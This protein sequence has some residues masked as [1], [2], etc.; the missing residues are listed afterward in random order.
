MPVTKLDNY[1][2]GLSVESPNDL[3]KELKDIL[4]KTFE[5]MSTQYIENPTDKEE[6]KMKYD[7]ILSQAHEFANKINSLLQLLHIVDESQTNKFKYEDCM[8]H[9][10]GPNKL[11]NLFLELNI[12]SFDSELKAITDCANLKT[13]EQISAYKEVSNRKMALD[14]SEKVDSFNSFI[15]DYLLSLAKVI[16]II[17]RTNI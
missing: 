10:M 11:A 16:V 1:F 8:I 12:D 9:H 13:E 4:P 14:F 17:K 6:Y 3:L 5:Y 15:N 2:R 7:N